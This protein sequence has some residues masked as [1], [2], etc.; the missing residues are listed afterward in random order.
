MHPEIEIRDLLIRWAERTRMGDVDKI[1]S[2]HADNV[3]IFDVLPP[4]FYE[5][6]ASYRASWN[7]WQPT[8]QRDSIFDL[9]DLKITARND[10]AF[11]HGYIHCGGYQKDG[12]KFEDW[13]RATF[14]LLKSHNGWEIT[15]QHISK[16][17][18][19]SPAPQTAR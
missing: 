3:L 16:P 7:D 19:S 5:G 4:I 18:M 2:H 15:H 9:L 11:A 13:V 6:K 12:Q 8:T 1:L 14:C 10:I 17:F